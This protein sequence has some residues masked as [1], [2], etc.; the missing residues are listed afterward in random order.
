MLNSGRAMVEKMVF[1]YHTH[2]TTK[3]EVVQSNQALY[4]QNELFRYYALGNFKELT[5]KVCLDNAMMIFLDGRDN[6]R[7]NVNE[8]F[9]RELLELYTI[10]KGPQTGP[11]DYTHYTE[12]DVKEELVRT[13]LKKLSGT[14]LVISMLAFAASCDIQ[15]NTVEPEDVLPGSTIQ[16]TTVTL[17]TQSVSHKLQTADT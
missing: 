1:F 13:L 7:N 3:E 8:N 17:F 15:E 10:G 9:G 16:I 5:R 11:G 2:F 6:D 12:Q 14:A 4:H